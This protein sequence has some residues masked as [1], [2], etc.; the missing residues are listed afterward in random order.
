MGYTVTPVNGVQ[1][2]DHNE[3]LN[4][5]AVFSQKVAAQTEPFTVMRFDNQAD[6][7]ATLTGSL[8]PAEGMV[9]WIK[10]SNVLQVYDGTAWKRVYP[11]ERMTYTGTTTP[12]TSLGVVGD[13]Y[14][15]F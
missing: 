15:Q 14:L 3:L 7:T 12:A 1:V 11:V 9:A 5:V 2:P 8:V 13:I 6:L 4:Q 10:D